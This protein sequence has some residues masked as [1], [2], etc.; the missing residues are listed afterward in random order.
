MRARVS[1]FQ[2]VLNRA[3]AEAATGERKTVRYASAVFFMVGLVSDES[4]GCFFSGRT[5][6]NR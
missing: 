1:E 5:M 3:K 6:A 4:W 2:K